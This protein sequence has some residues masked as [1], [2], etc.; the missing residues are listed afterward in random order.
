MGTVC[1]DLLNFCLCSVRKAP[2]HGRAD[3]L[4]LRASKYAAKGCCTWRAV[5]R[6]INLPYST[7]RCGCTRFTGSSA[8]SGIRRSPIQD[9]SELREGVLRLVGRSL[10]V[11]GHQATGRPQ[12]SG[13]R[14]DRKHLWGPPRSG[15][16]SRDCMAWARYSRLV[17]PVR[18]RFGSAVCCGLTIGDL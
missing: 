15:A 14:I 1:G 17:Q 2:G 12:P 5:C 9:F 16:P 13:A 10:I 11:L 4:R 18:P 7:T 6:A 8:G 3:T